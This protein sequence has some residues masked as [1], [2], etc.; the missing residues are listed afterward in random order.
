M[1]HT[2]L[3]VFWKDK[4]RRFCGASSSFLDYYGLDSV[5]DLLGKT[6]DDLRW[7]PIE[8]G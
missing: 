2:P 6:D 1:A 8:Q 7:H 5:H 3:K 4:D